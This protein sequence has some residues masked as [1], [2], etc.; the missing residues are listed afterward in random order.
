MSIILSDISYHYPNANFL[1]EHIDLSMASGEKVSII[2]NNGAGKSTLLKLLTGF[3]IPSC[4]VIQSTS[5]PYYIPQQVDFQ[6]Q[7]ISEILG[8]AEKIEALHSIYKWKYR[9]GSVRQTC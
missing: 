7:C 2:G 8:V 6:G 9:P 3:L 5:K 1:F 4:G